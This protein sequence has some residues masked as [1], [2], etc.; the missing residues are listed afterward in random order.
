[1]SDLTRQRRD[2]APAVARLG[3]DGPAAKNGA[4]Q[5]D[6]GSAP[7]SP[8]PTPA[9]TGPTRTESLAWAWRR[10]FLTGLSVWAAAQF[11][12]FVVNAMFWMTRNE[13]GPTLSGALEVWNRWDTGHYV[14]IALDGYNPATENPGFLPLYSMLMAALEPVLPGGML[15]A[16]L[17]IAWIACIA[18]LTLI[19]RLVDD[20]FDGRLAE[21]TIVF[22]MA[23]PFAFYLCAA[24]STSLFLA[25]SAASL[26]SMRR[27]HWWSAGIWAGLASGTRQTGVLLAIA[28]LV[29]YLRQRDWQPSRIRWD[30]AAVAIVPAGLLCYMA[31]SWHVF[32][33]PLKFVHVRSFWGQVA[34]WP[35]MGAVS[36]IDV[37]ETTAA[38]G[39]IFQPLVVL[40]VID[41]LS[42]PTTLVLLVLAVVGPWRLGQEATYLVVIAG[43]SLL[44]AL[45]LP[46]GGS[47]PL[48]G[49]PR[50]ALE[51]LPV[52]IVLARIGANRHLARFY[53][54]PAIAVQATLLIAFFNN[55]WLS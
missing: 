1:M 32:G 27:G 13:G 50:Y 43:F 55:L 39:H 47:T 38:S 4:G 42:V 19:Y 20:L 41:L 53:L 48:H 49:V 51:M 21:R 52:F 3:P 10:A 24:Y 15:S 29:E 7:R 9:R 44:T 8:E 33:D 18:A 36:T 45:M 30:A 25:L 35:W 2:D 12:Y 23:F 16:G 31:Y 22:V 6:S 11:A 54:M 40:N 34:T 17:I 5:L 28:F 26:Y 46:F 37:I 14:T